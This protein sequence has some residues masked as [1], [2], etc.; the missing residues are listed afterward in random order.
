MQ[1]KKMVHLEKMTKAFS[2]IDFW[3]QLYLQ[4]FDKKRRSIKVASSVK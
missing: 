1:E 2:V 4:Y 3:S